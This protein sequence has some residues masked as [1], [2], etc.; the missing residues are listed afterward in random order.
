MSTFLLWYSLPVNAHYQYTLCSCSSSANFT[1]AKCG[2]NGKNRL[3]RKK[4]THNSIKQH[5]N[6][7]YPIYSFSEYRINMRFLPLYSDYH[8][9]YHRLPKASE[10]AV[11]CGKSALF[12]QSKRNI[13]KV[14]ISAW[15]CG[16][17]H[18]TNGGPSQN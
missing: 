14:P 10:K 18:F 6:R 16:F 2:T 1:K 7:E 17:W 5:I 11:K 12:T 3:N 13:K 15:L 8:F 9:D 4:E